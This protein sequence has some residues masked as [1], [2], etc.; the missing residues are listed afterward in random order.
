MNAMAL[1]IPVLETERLRF[2]MLS[3]EDYEAECA[4]YATD[5][6]AG[7]GGP[8][9]PREVWRTLA[10]LIGH[11][12]IHGYG[13][14]ALEDKATG[15]YMGRAGFLNPGDWPEPEIGWTLMEHAEGK[16]LA[17]EAALAVRRFAYDTLGWTTAISL[18]KADNVRSAAL[19][20]RLGCS[21]DGVFHHAIAGEVPVWRH[22]GPEALA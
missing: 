8:H 18:I 7:V 22:P 17:Y 16:G 19:A 13:M 9:T 4:F 14:W 20:E 6:S 10:M 11:W 1:D 2:R 5:R 3:M 21:R 15:Q 12:V